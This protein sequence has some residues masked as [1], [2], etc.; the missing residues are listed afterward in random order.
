[1]CN[2]LELSGLFVCLGGLVKFSSPWGGGAEKMDRLWFARGD[3]QPSIHYI[4]DRII[5]PFYQNN[6]RTQNFFFLKL[7]FGCPTAIFGPFSR[8]RPHLP[9]V[10]HCVLTISTRRSPGAS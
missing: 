1:M 9:D 10:Y 3:Q 6:K 8:G 7:L 4:T 2:M 5:L